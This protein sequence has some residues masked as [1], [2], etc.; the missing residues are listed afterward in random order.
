VHS[1][2]DTNLW[3]FAAGDKDVWLAS[4]ADTDHLKADQLQFLLEGGSSRKRK[5]RSKPVA[6]RGAA[7]SSSRTAKRR[8]SAGSGCDSD[9]CLDVFF[10]S[11]SGSESASDG[12]GWCST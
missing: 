6:S 4:V 5:S 11:G 8:D 3:N 12:P 7:S 2:L 1:L 9:L 10:D